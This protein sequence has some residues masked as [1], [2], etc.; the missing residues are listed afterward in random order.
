MIELKENQW[1]IARTSTIYGWGRP[2]RPNIGLYVFSKLSKG[3]RI[4]MVDDYYSSP[5]LD[6]NLAS[7]LIEIA[8][9]K[10]S[11]IINVSG[12][13]RTT[14]YDFAVYLANSFK[15][16]NQLV[17]ATQGQNIWKTKRPRDVS[18]DISRASQILKNSPMTIDKALSQFSQSFEL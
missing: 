14:R 6:T 7:M 10:L 9:R 16:N 13:T 5:T 1:C 17:S 3:E 8:E 15:F 12:A 4:L 11:G 18:L 2:Y